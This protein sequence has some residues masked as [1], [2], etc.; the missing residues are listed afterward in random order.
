[1]A[2][3]AGG[4]REV[5]IDTQGADEVSGM[6]RAVEVF[7]QNA[8]ERDALL[9]ERAEAAARLEELVKERTRELNET[10]GT[11]EEASEVIA[12]SIRYASRIQRS[13]L[14]ESSF[15]EA[16]LSD[17]FI[18]WEPR[19][20]VSGDVYWMARWGDGLLIVLGDCTGH[21][22]PGA[23]MTLI[24]NSALERALL[25]VDPGAIGA[26]ISRMNQLIKTSLKQIDRVGESD[27]GMDLGMCYISADHS[28]VT[29]AGAG[30]SLFSAMPGEDL[31]EIKGGK[32]GIGYR[33]VPFDQTYSETHVAVASGMPFYMTSDGLI[34]QIGGERHR[35]F[36]L[37]R[38]LDLLNRHQDQP[39]A[40][41]K[42]LIITALSEYQGQEIRRDDVLVLGFRL[43]GSAGSSGITLQ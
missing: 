19:D 1:M 37:A 27:D 26:L 6:G 14:P 42:N 12:S 17:R 11:L 38:F 22:V 25:D 31:A 28:R 35:A 39:M 13:I 15:I 23:F 7:R 20:V 40:D 24:A 5:M 43:N 32:R 29:F 34:D 18:L 8:I 10:V 21:G 2:A 9:A 3:I 4:A 30:I 41:Q 16:T 36:G 33:R